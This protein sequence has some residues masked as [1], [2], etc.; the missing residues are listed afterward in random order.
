MPVSRAGTV[1]NPTLTAER[2]IDD[3]YAPGRRLYRTGDRAR[4]L[5]DGNIEFAGR[6]DQQLKIR[7]VRVEPG[8]IVAAL[9][10]HPGVHEAAVLASES[11]DGGRR[12]VV[13]YVATGE[14]TAPTPA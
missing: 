8:E 12:L 3:P 14:A 13:L 5:A 4:R 1:N 11:D 2:F 7:G 9:E 10:T 6:V